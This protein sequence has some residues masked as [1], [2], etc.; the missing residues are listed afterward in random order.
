MRPCGRRARCS[1]RSLARR[2]PAPRWRRARRDRATVLP[3]RRQR[4]VRRL[5]LRVDGRLRAVDETARGHRRDHGARDAGIVAL[6]PR[7]AGLLVAHV[8]VNGASRDVFARG[9][10]WWSRRG[11]ASG[12]SIFTVTSTTPASPRWITDPDRSI[13]G[14]SP[15]NDGAFVVSEPGSPGW[16]PVKVTPRDKATFDFGG[17][18]PAGIDSDGQRGARCQTTQPGS[19]TTW[20]WRESRSNAAAYLDVDARPL[21]P[22][23]SRA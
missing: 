17:T 7:S 3:D 5:A 9:R 8:L 6:R 1:S 22:R 13:E 18:V 4:R 16:Y 19:K 2:R 12:G 10:S 21:Q 11:R 14:G 20:V 15:T 23:Q